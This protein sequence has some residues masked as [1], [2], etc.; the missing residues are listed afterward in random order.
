MYEEKL[1][2]AHTEN[3][4]SAKGIVKQCYRQTENSEHKE[5]NTVTQAKKTR[6]AMN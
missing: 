5:C 4:A 3:S 1:D 6:K 2:P